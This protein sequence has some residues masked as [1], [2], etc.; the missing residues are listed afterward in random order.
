MAALE[1]QLSTLKF[2]SWVLSYRKD[3]P[4]SKS[5]WGKDVSLYVILFPGE[6]KDNTGI[7]RPQ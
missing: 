7:K 6:A 3:V 2:Y 4:P 1:R 5:P